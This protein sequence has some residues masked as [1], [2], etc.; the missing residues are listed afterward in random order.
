M[1]LLTVTLT[2]KMGKR[3]KS[4]DSMRGRRRGH[5]NEQEVTI[6]P[7]VASPELGGRSEEANDSVQVVA[8]ITVPRRNN[9]TW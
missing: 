9:I 6:H 5:I 3:G 1:N 8:A 2:P 7:F 4:G